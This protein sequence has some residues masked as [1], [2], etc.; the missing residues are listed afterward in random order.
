MQTSQTTKPTVIRKKTLRRSLTIEE[1]LARI[2]DN[3]SGTVT[4][5]EGLEAYPTTYGEILPESIPVL[6]EVFS[7]YAPLTKITMANKNFYDLGCGIG[8][9]VIG[10]SYL[11]PYLKSTGIEIVPE[12]VQRAN[13]ALLR[14]RD[15][16][17]K[18]RIELLCVSLLDDTV[19]YYDACWIYLSNLVFPY[20][21]NIK[22]FDKLAKEVKG[23]CI[24]IC[25]EPIDHP[26]FTQ[27]NTCSIPMSWSDTA[28]V[29]VYSKK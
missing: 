3:I 24:I 7:K 2:Y 26:M 27:I 11:N 10:F 6:F 8:K 5:L 17:I 18:K 13:E 14:I 4:N 9:I 23:G 15:D 19:H 29:I 28:K 20:E 22:I 21:M 16:T 12:R 1:R 25:C